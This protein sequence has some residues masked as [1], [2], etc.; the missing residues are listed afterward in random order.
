MKHMKLHFFTII[1]LLF[2]VSSCDKIDELTKFD[3]TYNQ[4]I[5]IPST[6]IINLPFS[7]F[8]PETSTN[9]ESTFS[10]N[11]TNRD[12][13]EDIRLTDLVLEINS[14]GDGNFNFLNSI[15]I[16]MSSEN[17]PE[18]KIAWK[19]NI[20][21]NSSSVLNLDTLDEDIKDYIKKDTYTLRVETVSDETIREDYNIN[22]ESVFF[23]DAKILGI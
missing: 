18:I 2:F 17:L 23:V 20:G 5:V 22:I 4:E 11:N 3:I 12:L 16:Y 15:E 1:T 21:N 8:T 10:N 19:E 6:S 7:I 14:P 9:S 13:I